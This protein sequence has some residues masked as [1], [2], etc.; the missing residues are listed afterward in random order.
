M[1]TVRGTGGVRRV[2]GGE[3]LDEERKRLE[4]K[5]EF[6][7][8]LCLGEGQE[9][10]EGELPIHPVCKMRVQWEEDRAC[11]DPKSCCSCSIFTLITQSKPLWGRFSQM[12]RTEL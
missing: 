11:A 9:R 2:S 10:A 4:H 7:V 6:S 1:R 3:R 8:G 5:D 12:N